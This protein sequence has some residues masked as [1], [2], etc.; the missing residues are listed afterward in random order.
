MAVGTEEREA[1]VREL[2]G[3][4]AAYR[5]VDSLNGALAELEVRA[6]ALR[7]KLAEQES[8]RDKAQASVEGRL[9]S[10]SDDDAD[11]VSGILEPYLAEVGLKRAMRVG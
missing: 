4:I 3:W 6:G 8:L 1:L 5:N 7:S 10:I 9:S 2:D 11:V